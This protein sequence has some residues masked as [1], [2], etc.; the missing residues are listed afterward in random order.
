MQMV[1]I[2]FLLGCYVIQ[3]FFKGNECMQFFLFVEL[4]SHLIKPGC[5]H[6]I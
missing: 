4:T 2:S 3:W 5:D 6:L 1:Y